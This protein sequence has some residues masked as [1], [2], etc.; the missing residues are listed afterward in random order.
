MGHSTVR[1]AL[2][3]QHT[4]RGRERQIAHRLSD[5]IEA[6]KPTANGHVAGTEGGPADG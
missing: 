5:A 3:Y 6:A 1:A 4:D 2:I